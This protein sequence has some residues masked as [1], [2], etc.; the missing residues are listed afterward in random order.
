MRP[1]IDGQEGFAEGGLLPAYWEGAVLVS[2]ERRGRPVA[3]FGY[4]EM[5]GYAE[6]LDVASIGGEGA[7]GR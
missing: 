6:R 2:G 7:A 5:T 1:R 4:L 3:G